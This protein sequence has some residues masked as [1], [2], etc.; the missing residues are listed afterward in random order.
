VVRVAPKSTF[1]A[2]TAALETTPPDW[3]ETVPEIVPEIWEETGQAVRQASTRVA[4]ATFLVD[5]SS[6]HYS[7]T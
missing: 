4:R 1:F 2:V 6:K 5:M 7:V 3:S